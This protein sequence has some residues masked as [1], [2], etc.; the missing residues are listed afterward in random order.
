[1][2]E[3]LQSGEDLPVENQQT[4]FTENHDNG[5]ESA[6]ATG[7]GQEQN[8]QEAANQ[9]AVNDAIN[10]QHKKFRDEERRANELQRQLEE[11]QKQLQTT[12][13]ASEIPPMPDAFDDDYAEKVKARDEAIRQQSINQAQQQLVMQ[14]QQAQQQQQAFEQ[15]QAQAKKVESYTSRAK[16]LNIDINDL[17]VAGQTVMS[18]GIGNDLAMAILDDPD[19]PLITNHLAANPAEALQ[20]AQMN[21]VQ[22]AMYIERTVRPKAA[23]LKPRQS[24]AP[25]P[26]DDVRGSGVDPDAGK[27]PHTKNAKFE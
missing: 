2:S 5:V 16:E 11:T 22:Q 27:Y 3:E 15:Q 9:Q 21:P 6:P 4:E 18:Y 25:A 24:S 14:Q 20:V 19:G 1:M 23:A 13:P 12:Q 17:Q 10:R 7:E 8:T 26:A